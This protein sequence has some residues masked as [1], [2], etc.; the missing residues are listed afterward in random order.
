MAGVVALYADVVFGNARVIGR[1]V[2]HYLAPLGAAVGAGLRGE[3]SL[4]WDS[5]VNHGLPMAARW[6]PMVFYPPQWLN[7][8]LAPLTAIAIGILI[9]LVLAGAAMFRLALRYTDRPAAAWVAAFAFST[10]GYLVSVSVAGGYLYGAALLPLSLLCVHRLV[11]APSAARVAETSLVFAL[12]LFVADPQTFFYEGVVLVPAIA[13]GHA[14]ATAPR[15]SRLGAI[16]AAG[17]LGIALGACQWVPSAEFGALSVRAAGVG[18]AD[19]WA[20]HP[21]RLLQLWSPAVFGAVTPE[22]TFW[23]RWLINAEFTMPWAPLLYVGLLPWAGILAVGWSRRA[24]LIAGLSAFF[25]LLA[26]GGWTPLFGLVTGLPGAGFFRYPEKFMLFV[27]LGLCLLAAMGL[28]RLTLACASDAPAAGWTRRAVGTA[29]MGVA[30]V[31]LAARSLLDAAWFTRTLAAHQVTHLDPV[32][33]HATTAASLLHTAVFAALLGGLAF[34]ARR[35]NPRV[36]FGLAG[37]V[38]I[39]DVVPAS[40]AQRY[41]ADGAAFDLPPAACAA[42][43]AAD[44]GLPPTAFRPARG[45]TYRDT[46]GEGTRFERQRRWEWD[47]LKPNCGAMSCVRFAAGYEAAQLSSYAKLWAALPDDER[48]FRLFGV[49][50]L[51]VPL[52]ALDAQTFPRLQT[53]DALGIAVHGV[54]DPLPFAHAVGAAVTVA[55]DAEARRLVGSLD[56]ARAVLLERTA[57]SA[58]FGPA[59][60]KAELTSYRPG[61][62]AVTTDF[63]RPGFLVLSETSYPGWTAGELVVERANGHFLGLEVPAGHRDIRLVFDPPLQR[64]ANRISFGA[65][66]V[67]ALLGVSGTLRRRMAPT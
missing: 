62:I 16:A 9:H 36:L 67:L 64:T 20:L 33:A 28:D 35:L 4:L 24:A 55:D 48:R 32:A 57:P 40:L 47:T 42:L 54:K 23:A 29:L 10:G 2:L 63:E 66:A 19:A 30:G 60:R 1:D 27:T 13:F 56:F 58:D 37:L 5:G 61:E 49:Q 14:R 12:Q 34:V 41:V 46:G 6:S 44:H 38:A 17:A 3:G 26:F 18:V 52:G 22:N 45:L 65:L 59:A 50:Q 21:L 7:A 15:V 25:L 8:A 11:E 39:A 31:A 53:S 43:P 51:V